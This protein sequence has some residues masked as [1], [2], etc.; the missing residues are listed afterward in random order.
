LRL[1]YGFSAGEADRE[2]ATVLAWLIWQAH[3]FFLELYATTWLLVV[4][5]ARA[6]LWLSLLHVLLLALL[7]PLG[8]RLAGAVGAAWGTIAAQAV[9]AALALLLMQ[10]S[11][12]LHDEGAEEAHDAG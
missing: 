2:A 9:A 6:A 12:S 3:L 7:L 10:Q 1:I 8:A 5:R 11:V 4:Q